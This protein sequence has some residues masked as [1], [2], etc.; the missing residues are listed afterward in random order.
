MHTT[1]FLQRPVQPSGR[2]TR[3]SGRGIASLKPGQTPRQSRRRTPSATNGSVPSGEEEQRVP[4]LSNA[5]RRVGRVERTTKETSVDI[6]IDLDGTGKC[7][8][9]T[10]IP[11]LNHMIEVR[12]A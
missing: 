2:T 3:S 8:V 9:D 10:P 5:G 4:A 1:G 6:S 7:T 11:F 12:G